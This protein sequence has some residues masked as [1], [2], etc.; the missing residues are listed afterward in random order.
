MARTEKTVFI[1]YRRA[2]VYIALAVYEILKNHGYDVFFDYRSISSGDF[3]QI[4][5]GNIRARAHF[6]LI[7]TPT[8]LDRCNEPGD[9]LRREIE[10]AIDEK[11]NIVPL[12]F[13]G[14]RFGAASVTKTLTGKLKNLGRYNG[15][16]VHEDYFDEGMDRLR[17]QFLNRPLN[18]VLHPVSTEVQQVVREEQ[19]AADQALEQIEDV[20]E[21]LKPTGAESRKA[22]L[23]FYGIVASILLMVMVGLAGINAWIQNN[24]GNATPTT[25]NPVVTNTIGVDTPA[26]DS[27]NTATV[28]I[29][30]STPTEQPTF[31]ITPSPT[32]GV[33]STR[34]STKDGMTL[35]YVPAGEFT[36]GSD[37]DEVV[38]GCLKFERVITDCQRSRFVGEEPPHSVNV[39][40]FWIDQTEVTNKMYGNCVSAGACN[41]PVDMS[42]GSHANYFGASEFENYPVIFVDW[43]MA[44]AY[45]SW[46]ERRLPS[47]AEWEKAARGTDANVYPW[48]NVFDGNIVNFCDTNCGIVHADQSSNDGYADVSPVGNYPSGKSIYGAHDMA[49]NVWEWVSTLYRPYPYD[50]NDGREN[51]SSSESRVLRGGSW[52]SDGNVVR[53]AIRINTAPDS[54]AWN[55]GVRCAMDATP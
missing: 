33:G 32:L 40:A 51:F 17:T 23:R 48:G 49:G 50:A 47:E 53:S 46:A 37:A 15:L 5:T 1:S 26:S 28:E 52:N 42:S 19:F 31:T 4:I 7:L 22:N 29:P 24:G 2:D 16:N 14:F 9:W 55:F 6:L 34:I 12:F 36:M 11:R 45:C 21:L 10:I 54:A 44:K 27:V 41:A 25:T 38:A 8:A 30:T 3:E 18:T 13:K 20:K 39:D 43:N 35:L